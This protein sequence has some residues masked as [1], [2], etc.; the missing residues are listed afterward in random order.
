MNETQLLFN[1]VAKPTLDHP[2]ARMASA[3]GVR[4]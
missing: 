2:F 4:L 1:L 3:E